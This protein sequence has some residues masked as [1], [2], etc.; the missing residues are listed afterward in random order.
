MG[1]KNLDTGMK[2]MLKRYYS[3][4][5]FVFFLV[6]CAPHGAKKPVSIESLPYSSTKQSRPLSA[7]TQV[8]I[9]GQINVTLHTGYRKPQ[10]I[11][12]GDPRDLAQ[13][14]TTISQNTLYVV[15]GR[16]FPHHGAVHADI[17]GQSLSRI[18]Y[19]GEGLLDGSRLHT[20]M[21]DVFLAN[22]GTTKLGGSLDLR[23]L[24]V[25][26]DG[27]TEI[28]GISSPYLQINL[29][30]NPKVQLEGVA[31]IAR[32]V[33]TGKAWFSLYWL[34]SDTLTIR[35]KQMAR[36]QLAGAVNKLDVELWGSAH[37]KGRYLRA[38]RSFVKTHGHAVAEI[39]SVNHQ[40]TL[41]TDAS[42]IYYYN[43]PNTRADFM[44]YDGS[45][46]DMR[47]W[48]RIEIRDFDRYNK[49]F[50]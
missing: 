27:L 41:A 49:Q 18:S 14:K 44:A 5:L 39:S 28:S 32:L 11:L 13:V 3:L 16:G 30:G 29:M 47:E 10:I 36:I 34:K 26:G 12:S 45:V 15:L 33:V 46:L 43:L 37:F 22:Q 35:G 25:A 50:P 2:I 7:F 6:S 48:D 20:G 42:D 21:L 38:Q 17:Q 23:Q 9:Q 19:R 40:S 1:C 8:D 4:I 31:N 24:N